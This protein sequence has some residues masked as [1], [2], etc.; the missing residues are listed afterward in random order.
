MEVRPPRQIVKI[1]EVS[2]TGK[3]LVKQEESVA[4]NVLVVG[5]RYQIDDVR[6]MC[7]LSLGRFTSGITGRE[8]TEKFV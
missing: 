6:T 5:P 7:S 1:K 3:F 2:D 8:E 4:D